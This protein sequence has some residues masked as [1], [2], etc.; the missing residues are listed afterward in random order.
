MIISMW[1][2]KRTLNL[3]PFKLLVLVEFSQIPFQLL[4]HAP[5]IFFLGKKFRLGLERA[6]GKLDRVCTLVEM[7]V[8]F[9]RDAHLHLGGFD[10]ILGIVWALGL[11]CLN[12]AKDAAQNVL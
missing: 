6:S 7:S 3:S 2:S 12:W 4:Y 9:G 1:Q 11:C 8:M 10:C 5:P